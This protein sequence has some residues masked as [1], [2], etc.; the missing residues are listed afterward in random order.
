MNWK[1]LTKDVDMNNSVVKRLFDE[2]N[3]AAPA[4]YLGKEGTAAMLPRGSV[5]GRCRLCGKTGKLTKEHIPLF[6][7]GNKSR[8]NV[9]T[10]DDWLKDGIDENPESKHLIEQGGIFGYTL[11]GSCNSFTGKHYGNEYKKW[12][13]KAEEIISGFGSGIIPR[14]N[15]EIGPFAKE[16]TFGS[17]E[18]GSIKPGAFVRQVLSGMCSLSGAWNLAERYPVLRRIILEQATESLPKGIELGMSLYVGPKV[19]ICGP[20]LRV[21]QKTETWRWCQEI[22]FPPFAFLLVI[23]SNKKEPGIGLMINDFSVLTPVKEQYFSGVIEIGFGWSPYPGDYRSQ[24]T[25]IAGRSMP[26]A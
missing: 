2:A 8:H 10:L 3:A 14:L 18:K 12:V 21:D 26:S 9:L 13:Q 4:E 5:S 20:Q 23:A 24:A 22:A 11:C 1:I 15:K 19:R 16:V 6:A 17:K 25:I 7:S